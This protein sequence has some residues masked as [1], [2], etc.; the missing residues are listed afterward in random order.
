MFIR[1]IYEKIVF[2]F[3]LILFFPGCIKDD[4]PVVEAHTDAYVIKRKIGD[5]EKVAIA[6]YAFANTRLTS[7][8]VTP[9]PGLGESF[10]LEAD[11][12]SFYSFYKD[13]EP[14]D[15][16]TIWPIESDYHFEVFTKDGLV[17]QQ[18]DH[19]EKAELDI[20]AIAS[21]IYF[22]INNALKVQWD[23]YVGADGIVLKLLDND[24]D[25]LFISHTIMPTSAES[26]IAQGTGNWFSIVNPGDRIILQVQSIAYESNVTEENNMYNVATLSIAEK[27]IV[28]GM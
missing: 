28:W 25:V 10:E 23:Q 27:N 3:A 14:E 7:V 8:T 13:P 20:P 22:P 19:L 24:R 6:F 21:T 1:W 9:A 26:F 2:I 16:K 5:E 4:E 17:I 11:S 18:T 15:F 12:M